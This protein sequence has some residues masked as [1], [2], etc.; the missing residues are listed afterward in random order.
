[1]ARRYGGGERKERREREGER[2]E[3]E[4]ERHQFHE[5]ASHCTIIPMQINEKITTTTTEISFG[6][7][8]YRLICIY[9]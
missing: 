5:F 8:T 1:M 4:A 2:R 7:S 9:L 6:L 3:K